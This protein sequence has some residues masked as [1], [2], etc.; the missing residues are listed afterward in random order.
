MTNEWAN[1]L[2]DEL[3]DELVEITRGGDGAGCRRRRGAAWS[4][5]R[6]DRA[7]ARPPTVAAVATSS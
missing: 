2:R 1:A 3:L 4:A 7:A 5:A 6:P